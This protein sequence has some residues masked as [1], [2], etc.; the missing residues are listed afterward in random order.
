MQA[1][2][3]HFSQNVRIT[4]L[5][6]S[7]QVCW[8]HIFVSYIQVLYIEMPLKYSTLI[9]S[10]GKQSVSTSTNASGAH[11][12]LPERSRHL[13]FLW[14]VWLSAVS[15]A[16]DASAG[17]VQTTRGISRLVKLYSILLLVAVGV[18]HEHL[19]AANSP[20]LMQFL[21]DKLSALLCLLLFHSLNFVRITF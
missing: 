14:N 1:N 6:N 12:I 8:K 15:V 9:S 3:V 4:F 21:R 13:H 2:N 17:G 18:W 19:N 11:S 5:W 7:V 16:L 20:H 10:D